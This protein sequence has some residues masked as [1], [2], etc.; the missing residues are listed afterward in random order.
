MV[1]TCQWN[2]HR[3]VR[4]AKSC[5]FRKP[6]KVTHMPFTWIDSTLTSWTAKRKLCIDTGRVSSH[7]LVTPHATVELHDTGSDR[8]CVVLVP[9]G[10]NVVAHYTELIA[11]LKDHFRVLC[12][13]MPGFGHSIPSAGYGH[14]LDQ[15]AATVIAVLDALKIESA[16]LAFSCA[17]GFY[18]IRAA[19]LAPARVRRLVL[20]QTP[21]LQ[22]MHAWSKRIVPRVLHVPVIGQI[23][24]WSSRRKI[25]S[26]W[27][28]F[29]L[30][31]GKDVTAF[32]QA[33][34]RSL[35]RG[36][37]FC[38]AGVVQGLGREEIASLRGITT[39]CTM[40]WGISDRSHRVTDPNS[41][42]ELVPHARIILLENCGHFPDVE[43]PL[44]IAEILKEPGWP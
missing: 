10:P 32:E 27:Y 11:L 34:M 16:T 21:S 35:A 12:F 40:V 30:P 26:G 44:R 31:K 41:L 33:A 6:T 2:A 23:V 17:N 5:P 29:A 18:A 22:A 9:D 14:S 24:G 36:G 8:P 1:L 20:S 7:P 37:C 42:L 15:G 28:N 39:P 13:D 4:R 25:A 38:L 43:Y 19:Q 3:Q